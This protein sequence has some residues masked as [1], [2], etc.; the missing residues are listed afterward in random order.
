V[1]KFA[2]E[3][4]QTTGMNTLRPEVTIRHERY[5]SFA[6]QQTAVP[7]HPTLRSHRI[8]IGLY[9]RDGA[10]RIVRRRRVEL[11]IDGEWTSVRELEGERVADLVL[12]NDDDLTFAK[13]R[14]DERSVQTLTDDLSAVEDPLTVRSK[15][16]RSRWVSCASGAA[17]TSGPAMRGRRRTSSSTTREMPGARYVCRWATVRMAASTS[18]ADCS[19]LA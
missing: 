12:V 3:W 19:L 2:H 18:S 1:S 8:A 14:F 17:A 6:V 11:D 4:L 7:E 9:D 5:A 15:I 10:G 13:I 16:S